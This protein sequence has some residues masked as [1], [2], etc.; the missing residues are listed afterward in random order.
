[1]GGGHIS[2]SRFMG[3]S[4][5]FC[6]KVINCE[7]S[8]WGK[9]ALGRRDKKAPGSVSGGVCV[10]VGWWWGGAWGVG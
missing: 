1:M 10:S 4:L 6:G 8:V 2:S 5:F 3:S 7:P 9:G